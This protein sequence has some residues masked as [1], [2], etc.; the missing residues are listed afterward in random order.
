MSEC[1]KRH[2]LNAQQPHGDHP[3]QGANRHGGEA[4]ERKP[5]HDAINDSTISTKSG[6]YASHGMA[7][8]S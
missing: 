5:F 8:G 2:P 3:T 6:L 1:R 4:G 7:A